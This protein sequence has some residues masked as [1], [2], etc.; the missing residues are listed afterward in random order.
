MKFNGAAL[1]T[2]YV[3]AVRLKATGTATAASSE[4]PVLVTNPDSQVST[5]SMWPCS[6]AR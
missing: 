2:T 3:S 6:A 1:A 5:P 4:V